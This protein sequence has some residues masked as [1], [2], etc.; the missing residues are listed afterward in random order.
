MLYCI[1][2]LYYSVLSGICHSSN[3]TCG[4]KG[5]P[6][7]E[8]FGSEWTYNGKCCNERPCCKFLKAPCVPETCPK[9][10]KLLS[11]QTSSANCYYTNNI[12]RGNHVTWNT[13]ADNCASTDGAYLWRP[14]TAQEANA[15]Q[16]E[17]N[18]PEILLWTGANDIDNDGTFTFAIENGPFSFNDLPFGSGYNSGKNV[19]VAIQKE[20]RFWDWFDLPCTCTCA[21]YIC[22]YKLVSILLRLAFN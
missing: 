8:T 5:V 22:E 14:N 1:G 4:K 10:F 9:G 3:G 16:N 17:F 21:R 15:V 2:V 20:G 7:N 6:C 19:C 13:A 12:N 11:N 18:I